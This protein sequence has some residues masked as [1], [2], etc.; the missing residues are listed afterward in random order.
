VIGMHKRIQAGDHIRKIAGEDVQWFSDLTSPKVRMCGVDL[1]VRRDGNPIAVHVP[2]HLL[3]AVANHDRNEFVT[4]R[5]RLGSIL[6]VAEGT[7]ADK[8]GL[9]VGDSILRIND[10]SFRFFDEFQSELMANKGGTV[11]LHLIRGDSARMDLV[12]GV[13]EDGTLGI[14]YSGRLDL[15]YERFQYGFF[16]ALPIGA[17]KAWS[18]VADNV[19]GFGKIF[20]GEVRAD[21]ALAGPVGIGTMFG[22]EVNWLRFCTLVGL[23][24][25]ILAF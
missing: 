19:K 3:N 18:T 15:P 6:F 20:R 8:A 2:T 4:E 24:S 9:R 11:T 5:T 23:L 14:N 10:K 16:A 13:S 22:T 1:T 25:L 7:P 17:A 12:S 21:K